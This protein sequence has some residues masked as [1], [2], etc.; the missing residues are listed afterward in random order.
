MRNV[1]GTASPLA[2]EIGE[3]TPSGDLAGRR[4]DALDT[5]GLLPRIYWNGA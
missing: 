1:D 3:R 5:K 4:D 2:L